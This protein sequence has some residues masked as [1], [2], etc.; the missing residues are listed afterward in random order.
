MST[1]KV[2]GIIVLSIIIFIIYGQLKSY[3]YEKELERNGIITIGKIDSIQ[4]TPKRNYLYLSYYIGSKKY[5]SFESG[6]HKN[7][8]PKDIGKFYKIKYLSNSPEI[9]RGIYSAE[10]HNQKEILK[11]GFSLEEIKK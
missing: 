1:K 6:L 10:I 4:E 2:G 7:V 3:R 5:I 9:I 8:L 11:S